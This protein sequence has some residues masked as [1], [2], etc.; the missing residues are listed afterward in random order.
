MILA[1][2]T[3]QGKPVKVP[4][5]W[6]AEY[7]LRWEG[8]GLYETLLPP[9]NGGYL[10]FHGVSALARV[11]LDGV[12]VTEHVGIWD[13]FSVLVP[14]SKT[15]TTIRVEVAKNGGATL[16]VERIA[17]GFLPYVFHTFGG[18]YKAVEFVDTV[19]DPDPAMAR[20]EFRGGT[21]LVDGRPVY[22][23][24]ILHWGWYPRLRCPNPDRETCR[25]EIEALRSMGFQCVKFCLW[26]PP[27]HYLEELERADMLAWMELPV[28]N[29]GTNVQQVRV[30]L[31]RIVRQYR[32]HRSIILWTVGCE[33]GGKIS[34][35]DRES[36]YRLVKDLTGGLT[37]DSSGG[38]EMYGGDPVE[39]GDFDD[40]HPYCDLAEFPAVLDTIV[41]NADKP[42][43]LG[44][45]NDFDDHRNLA[46]A[47][48]EYWAS[49]DPAKND[50]GVRW[51]YDL[52]SVVRES[53]FVTDE[54]ADRKLR[55]QSREMKL[56]AHRTFQ[57]WV[58]SRGIAGAVTTG[59]ADTPISTS[60]LF[61]DWG[62]PK[63]DA[64]TVREFMGSDLCFRIPQRRL[65][66]VNG[67]NRV[68]RWDAWHVFEGV[69][70]MRLGLHCE[71]GFDGEFRWVVGDAQ[72]SSVVRVEPCEPTQVAEIVFDAPASGTLELRVEWGKS[73]CE[74]P[75]ESTTRFQGVH[76]A[77]V[78]T[79][80]APAFREC[81]YEF[82]NEAL[83]QLF[84]GKPHTLFMSLSDRFLDPGWCESNNAEPLMLRIDTRTCEEVPVV[85]RVSGDIVHTLRIE[86]DPAGSLVARVLDSIR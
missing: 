85:A 81:A 58:R 47:S 79:V 49:D 36:L 57:E 12:L 14:A 38:A 27:H 39:F 30:E 83:E 8:P 5:V 41:R 25:Q 55:D 2:W 80:C 82:R 23:R 51:Q 7:D 61:D 29:P 26:V 48:K 62:E 69:N 71:S 53:R 78:P 65:P 56:F 40:F 10:Q 33:L 52:P 24:G 32:H 3:F 72:G 22:L 1:D 37:K 44:E 13:A 76:S 15:P 28:W 17:S 75:I 84:S 9:Q 20:A 50:K 67:G 4:H 6:G 73:G 77:D 19:G 18:I 16:P 86:N 54:Q 60:G 66:W 35:L 63:F 59:I 74:W 42:I 64:A 45:C 70:R 43:L 68:G 21:L 11:F 31:D 34:R 46:R